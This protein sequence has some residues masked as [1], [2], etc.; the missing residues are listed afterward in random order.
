MFVHISWLLKSRYRFPSGVQKY[1]PLALSTTI[2]S[3]RPCTA[4]SEIVCFFERAAI[5]SL[6]I[7]D[8]V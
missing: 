4:H 5:S 3:T 8:S 1:T 6:V 7:A 2:G